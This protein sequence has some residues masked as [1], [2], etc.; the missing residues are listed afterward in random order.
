MSSVSHKFKDLLT[1]KGKNSTRISTDNKFESNSDYSLHLPN[2]AQMKR[3]NRLQDRRLTDFKIGTPNTQ[4][5]EIHA[6]LSV[7]AL[8]LQAD[9]TFSDRVTMKSSHSSQQLA[10]N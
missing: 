1:S 7:S 10:K 8:K 6:P 3:A 9:N 4:C 2:T 5:R